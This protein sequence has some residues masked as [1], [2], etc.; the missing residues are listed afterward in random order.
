MRVAIAEFKQES[1]TFVPRPTTR[2]DFEAW[3]LWHGSDG[4][5]GSAGTNAAFDAAFDELAARVEVLAGRLT[6]S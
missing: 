4:V 1:N 5:T 2:A 6:A 3:H